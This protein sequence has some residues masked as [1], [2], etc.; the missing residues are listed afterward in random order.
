MSEAVQ[1]RFNKLSLAKKSMLVDRFGKWLW[2]TE[3]GT[4][5]VSV[6]SIRGE[7]IEVWFDYRSRTIRHIRIPSYK[8]L[9]VH[10]KEIKLPLSYL[11]KEP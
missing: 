2:F 9:D 10:L 7:I 8:D 11:T 4:Y 3:T 6:Y 5:R 1:H